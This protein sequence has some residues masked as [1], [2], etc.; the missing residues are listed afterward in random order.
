[1]NLRIVDNFNNIDLDKWDKFINTHPNGNI[2]QTSKYL[3]LFTDLSKF[4]TVFLACI[5]DEEI[6]GILV[7]VIQKEYSGIL[8]LITSRSITWGGPLL[9]SKNM[10]VLDRLINAFD[11]IV[12]KRAVYS[13]FRNIFEMEWAKEYLISKGYLFEEHLNFVFD[14]NKDKNFLWSS[15]HQTRRKQINRAYKKGVICEVLKEYNINILSEIYYI[16]Q[17]VYKK[18]KLPFPEFT[19]FKSAFEKLFPTSNLKIFLAKYENQII[20]CRL[21]LCYKDLLYDW[22]A[23]SKIEHYD[24]YPNDV[25]PW[26]IIKWGNENGYKKFDFGGAGKPNIP[27][28]VREYKIKFGGNLVNYGRFTKVNKTILMFLVTKG[29]KIWQIL[30]S[31]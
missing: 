14:L 17:S 6:H 23:G 10:E 5:C 15:I 25:L 4:E 16:L 9:K 21:L 19:F 12:S 2:F 1:M 13:Q 24:K 28:G 3:S 31:K 11:Q 7:S 29:F 30:Y 18:A 26:E 27:Y 20:G 8:G 22:Y